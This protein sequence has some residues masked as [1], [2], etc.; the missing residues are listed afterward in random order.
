[1]KWS[2]KRTF[3]KNLWCSV[4]IQ[5][6]RTVD[7][8]SCWSKI[9]IQVILLA[10]IGIAAPTELNVQKMKIPCTFAQSNDTVSLMAPAIPSSIVLEMF[11]VNENKQTPFID[12]CTA[13]GVI[14]FEPCT[15]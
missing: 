8:F 15:Q 9:A 1:M 3:L 7:V 10:F 4:A 2:F 5:F 14:G 6:S 12:E 11:K 13:K